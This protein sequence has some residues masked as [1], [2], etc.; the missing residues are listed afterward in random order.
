MDRR[1]LSGCAAPT[2]GCLMSLMIIRSILALSRCPVCPQQ[3]PNGGY[4][5]TVEC[6]VAPPSGGMTLGT[7]DE[8]SS[9]VCLDLPFV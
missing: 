6:F 9:Q 4:L 8:V 1:T 7:M 3:R 5:R 2:S